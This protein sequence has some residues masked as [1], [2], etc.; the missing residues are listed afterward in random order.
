MQK[1][2]MN[3]MPKIIDYK[4]YTLRPYRPDEDYRIVKKWW[5]E[6]DGI[7]VHKEWL[8][9]LGVVVEKDDEPIMMSWLYFSNSKLAQIGWTTTKPGINAKTAYQAVVL[10]VM[11]LQYL[12]NKNGATYLHAMSNKSGLTKVMKRLGFNVQKEYDYLSYFGG[13]NGS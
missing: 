11:K 12:A 10:G 8:S 2:K 7:F 6:R 5:V 1:Y 9:S 3:L 4:D 13:M